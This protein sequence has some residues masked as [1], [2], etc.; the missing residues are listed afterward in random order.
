MRGIL[1][2]LDGTLIDS[3]PAVERVWSGW[4]LE[5]GVAAPARHPHG[6]PAREAVRELAPHLDVDVEARELTRR[7][8]TDTD[9]VRPLPGATSLLAGAAGVPVAIVTSCTE[10]LARVRLGAAGLR[11]PDVLV[12]AERTPRVKPQPDPYRLGARELGLDPADCVVLE[13]APAGIA[14][15]VA[16]GCWVVGLRSGGAGAGLAD[17]HEVHD[18]VAT[19]LAALGAASR[20]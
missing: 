13:D 9:G 14:A 16:A 18:D 19:F 4:L 7:E 12:T 2:D 8:M 3:T 17:A 1:S 11:A 15:G 6:I 5:R 10:P 20:G